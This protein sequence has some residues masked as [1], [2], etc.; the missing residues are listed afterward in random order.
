MY[1]YNQTCSSKSQYSS[2]MHTTADDSFKYLDS[3]YSM[4]CPFVGFLYEPEMKL[5]TKLQLLILLKFFN[6]LQDT[7]AKI[8]KYS[9]C[10]TCKPYLMRSPFW[11]VNRSSNN[12][13]SVNVCW[14]VPFVW[15]PSRTT[16]MGLPLPTLVDGLGESEAWSSTMEAWQTSQVLHNIIHLLMSL[17]PQ[18][19]IHPGAQ[20][21]LTTSH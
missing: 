5:Q 2:S 14:E 21:L 11:Q 3:L 12:Q 9:K 18:N 8:P 16:T 17:P 13:E 19:I 7:P 6:P 1:S 20:M 10:N 15:G 4:L